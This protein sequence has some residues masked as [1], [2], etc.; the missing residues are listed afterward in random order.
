MDKEQKWLQRRLGMI[1]ASE[2]GQ[3]TSASGKII[4]GN[5]SYIRAKRWERKHGFTHPI[6]ARAMEI[7]NEQEP[8]IY[9]WALENLGLKHGGFDSIVYS[10]DLPE[11]PFWLAKDCPLG[12]SPDAFTPDES[13]VF[14]FKTL[15][16]ASATE[17][18]GD[19][20]TSYEEKKSAVWKDHG[21]Q[22]LGQFLSNQAVEEIWLIKYI[23]QDDDILK[24]LESPLAAWRGLVFKFKRSDFAS[25][26]EAMKERV[27][28]ID[29]MIDAPINP[30]EF[31]KG[32]WYVDDNGKLCK[33]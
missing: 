8:M 19:E 29:K 21:D 3:I 23:Y 20:Y 14:E 2:L 28:L 26:M 4:D 32:E 17:F 15:V 22:L 33:R 16:G 31:K 1:T 25:S 13:I 9:Q 7:G 27:I 18:F 5:L 6:T 11:I 12:A 24:D 10:K 30:S